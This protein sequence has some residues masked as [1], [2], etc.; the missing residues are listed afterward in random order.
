M[1][2]VIF[3]QMGTLLNKFGC[4]KHLEFPNGVVVNDREEIFISDNRTHSVKVFNYD[5]VYLRQIG[6][7]GITNYPIGVGINA[8][9][10]ILVADNHN[11]FNLTIFTQV[12]CISISYAKYYVTQ[13]HL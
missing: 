7:E 6:G 2:V 12:R 9:G 8:K 5:G 4:S 11:N 3:D 13:T 10:E 1:R